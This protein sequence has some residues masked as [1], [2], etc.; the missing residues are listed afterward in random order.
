[1]VV[2]CTSVKCRKHKI[3]TEQGGGINALTRVSQHLTQKNMKTTLATLLVLLAS[4]ICLPAGS[5]EY[6]II[7]VQGDEPSPQEI[8]RL[9][10]DGLLQPRHEGE[11]D[12]KESVPFEIDQTSSVRYPKSFDS[13]GRPSEWTESDI[14]FKL[15]G[16]IHKDAQNYTVSFKVDDSWKV[17][18]KIY[19]HESGSAMP[20]PIFGRRALETTVNIVPSDNWLVLGGQK[21]SDGDIQFVLV[22]IKE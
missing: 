5:L 6:R 9:Y 10:K 3:Q 19:L 22:R 17:T 2:P 4:V 12:F 18:D 20:Q 13:T 7:S 11:I 8:I 1:M 21:F 16:V 14:G 15:G